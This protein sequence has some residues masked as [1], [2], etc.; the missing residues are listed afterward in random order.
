MTFFLPHFDLFSKKISWNK[1][2][3]TI[4]LLSLT[5]DS[6]IDFKKYKIIPVMNISHKVAIKGLF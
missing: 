6:T 2:K 1:K 5:N 3:I 4:T